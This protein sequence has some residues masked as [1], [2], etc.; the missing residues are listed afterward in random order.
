M[1]FR[2]DQLIVLGARQ[3]AARARA[4]GARVL[5]AGIGQAFFAARIAQH[6]LAA[7]GYPLR[8]MVETGLYDVDCGV[9]GHGYLLAYD[10]VVRARRLSAIDDILGVLACGADNR[11]IAALGAAQIDRRGNLNSTRLGGKLLVGSGGA[12]DIAA[13]V[14]EVVVMTRLSPGRLVDDVE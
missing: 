3:L 14:E 2:S 13:L 11:C 6:E 1:L 8:V 4:I 10:N 12:C 7:A 9:D 5:I